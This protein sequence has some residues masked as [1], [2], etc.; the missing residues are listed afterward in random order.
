MTSATAPADHA[1]IAEAPAGHARLRA[2]VQEVAALTTPDRVV[3][4]DGSDDEWT[5]SRP[6][7]STPG[8]PPG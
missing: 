3:W 8:P 5:G 1:A 6:A 4:V 2:W 7:S